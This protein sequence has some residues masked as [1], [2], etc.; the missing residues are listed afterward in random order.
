M[1]KKLIMIFIASVITGCATTDLSKYK[2]NPDMPIVIGDYFQSPPSTTGGVAFE[3]IGYNNTEKTIK[4]VYFNMV[5]RSRTD[6]IVRDDISGLE[7]KSYMFV[8]PF[9]REGK[10]HRKFGPH[11]YNDAATCVEL[12]EVRV[13]YMDGTTL[14]LKGE[15]LSKTFAFSGSACRNVAH[16]QE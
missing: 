5:H 4:Y 13:E 3:F 16:H 7:V 12:K 14:E 11:F 2:S 6:D 15:S 1:N 8:G 10:F 9:A